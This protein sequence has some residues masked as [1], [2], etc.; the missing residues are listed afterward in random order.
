MKKSTKRTLVLVL[1]PVIVLCGVLAWFSAYHSRK[2]L[3]NI[4]ALSV[5]EQEGEAFALEKLEGYTL[6]QLK[7]IWGEPDGMLS[8]M[9][10]CVWAFQKPGS[11]FVTVYFD[12]DSKV[13]AVK[14]KEQGAE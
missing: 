4:P 7:E 5:I 11:G 12:K 14:F 9:F 6:D 3:D 10:G 2:S 8:G 1:V 13:E